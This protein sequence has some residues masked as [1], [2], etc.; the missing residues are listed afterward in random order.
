MLSRDAITGLKPRQ[1]KTL[2]GEELAAFKPAQIRS[3]DADAI[4]GLRPGSLNALSKRQVRA[5]TDDQLAG[6]SKKQIRKV[7]DFL[8][9]LSSR[10]LD[11]LPLRVGRSSRPVGSSNDVEELDLILGS[12]PLA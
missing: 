2:T 3:I 9:D 10:Q 11:A 7:E 12:D 1:L 6:L 4:S 5:F 8:E